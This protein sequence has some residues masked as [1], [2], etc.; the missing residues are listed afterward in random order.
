MIH[1]TPRSLVTGALV[2][3][4]S[5]SAASTASAQ[6]TGFAL[7]RYEPTPSDLYFASEFPWY[8]GASTWSLR[9]GL[10]A[11]YARNPLVARSTDGR[12]TALV[13]NM[14][15][16]HPQVGLSLFNRVGLHLSLPV[17]VLQDGALATLGGNT[18]GASGTVGV[19]DLRIGARVRLWNDADHDAASLHVSV[20]GFA[21]VA[22][23][24]SNLGDGGF[25]VRGL[26][27][28]AGHPGP[29]RYSVG[30]GVHA[31]PDF[32]T[33]TPSSVGTEVIATAAVGLALADDRFTIGPEAWM[34]RNVSAS[35]N[36]RPWNGEVIL[37]AHYLVAD[38]VLLGLGG[39]VGL[40]EGPGTPAFRGLFQV[41]YAPAVRAAAPPVD[42]DGD[43]VFDSEDVCVDVP[44]GDTPDP[45]RAGCPLADRDRDGVL[46]ADDQC[47]DVARGP[48]EDPARRGCPEGDRD[49]DTVL[50]SADRCPDE[51]QGDT[52]D[53][54][55]RG[56]PD[57][58]RD[59]DTVRDS[60]DVC[61]DEPRGLVPDPS[62]EGCPAP[63]RDHD[64]VPDDADHC[65]DEPGAPS[66]DP[67]RNG[68]PG[69]VRVEGGNI[70]IL[71]QV[72][73]DTNR[74]TIKAQS[75]RVLNA[76]ADV[77]R[78]TPTIRR[79]AIEGHTDNVG[80][81]AHNMDLSDRRARAVLD[82]LVAHGIEADRLESHGYGPTRPIES[83]ANAAGR[84]RN[85]RVEFHIL[86]P[87]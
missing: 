31:R 77:L 38:T 3:L 35:D 68:C 15:V 16:L 54:R 80:G 73:F 39:G 62:R 26:V 65:P 41:A 58:D 19:G 45:A 78:V 86:D 7:D 69:L 64:T 36:A 60:V 17:G 30:A 43:G 59:H 24:T 8:S 27:T 57:G 42:T 22:D 23:R 85:R 70:R 9:V 75:F 71:E 20:Y 34:A 55:R 79:V 87:Q 48:H 52:P 40:S 46:D 63:D 61:P 81:E 25:R 29:I 82:W 32:S 53:P 18:L 49:H 84:A 11:D 4:A 33:G 76:V 10:V 2:A 1:R 5:L 74:A 28:L 72:F 50:D 13:E 44:Q 83:N 6:T 56:C 12:A 51:A 47:P 14:L 37:G 67:N 21:P 66:P